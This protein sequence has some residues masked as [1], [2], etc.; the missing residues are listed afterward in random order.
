MAT[1]TSVNQD[2]AIRPALRM[3]QTLLANLTPRQRHI[4][5]FLVDGNKSA[6][7]I[8]KQL[9]ITPKVLQS[10][11]T[12]IY[13]EHIKLFGPSLI[14][15]ALAEKI[16]EAEYELPVNSTEL[17]NTLK[18]SL[19]KS[20]NIVNTA[21]TLAVQ[22]FIANKLTNWFADSD[23]TSD[24]ALMKKLANTVS[25]PGSSGE[26]RTLEALNSIPRWDARST[27]LSIDDAARILRDE[28]NDFR[29][30]KSF[31]ANQA[32]CINA[33]PKFFIEEGENLNKEEKAILE[34]KVESN[35]ELKAWAATLGEAWVRIGGI[36]E[37]KNH[38]LYQSNWTNYINSIVSKGVDSYT[39]E[40][41][42]EVDR[43]LMRE[44]QK[45]NF[46][47]N[48]GLATTSNRNIA[49]P[50]PF[51]QSTLMVDGSQIAIYVDVNASA[52]K[53]AQMKDDLVFLCAQDALLQKVGVGVSIPENNLS[54]LI[55]RFASPKELTNYRR[56]LDAINLNIK[57]TY[58]EI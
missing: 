49:N 11:E 39:T 32:K 9:A 34:G 24:K 14:E 38:K 15:S 58:E 36:K 1:K 56:A 57:K 46:Y 27:T 5:A 50:K 25:T 2:G 43:F 48:L 8:S 45:E 23:I 26:Q 29:K 21:V 19:S 51:I 40:L 7:E 41:I 13:D 20:T 17:A 12:V 30:A 18:S 22:D 6:S 31:L 52:D 16:N 53:L 33:F 35:S 28:T 42:S 4:L 44:D 10:E 47:R 55:V 37:A 3:D 54:Q